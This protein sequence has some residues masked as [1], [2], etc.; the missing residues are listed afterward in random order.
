MELS[1]TSYTKQEWEPASQEAA[2]IPEDKLRG[3]LIETMID[4]ARADKEIAELRT[5]LVAIKTALG[6]TLFDDEY[7]ISQI[8]HVT[9]EVLRCESLEQEVAELREKLAAAEGLYG[10]YYRD[11]VNTA[12][13]R[14]RLRKALEWIKD[15]MYNEDFDADL[16]IARIDEALP[17]KG[18][19]MPKKSNHGRL[20]DAAMS[21]IED[22]FSDTTV[23]ATKTQ[24]TLR[25]VRDRCGEIIQVIEFA[26]TRKVAAQD[27][28]C[29]AQK[30]SLAA[31]GRGRTAETLPN[32]QEPESSK[33]A[34]PHSS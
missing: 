30:A 7:I 2:K 25:D 19:R 20:L 15:Q 4:K 5:K 16:V 13:K 10:A 22:L 24:D 6:I 17:Q 33:V 29:D 23:P 3:R 8:Q 12:Q 21:A 26:G 11:L 27:Q 18:R 32:I 31:T 1:Q 28:P 9:N 34:P 14:D